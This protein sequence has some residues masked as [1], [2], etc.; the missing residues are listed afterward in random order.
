VG[1]YHSPAAPPN[2]FQGGINFRLLNQMWR[3]IYD[4]I[5]KYLG[6]T[7][8]LSSQLEDQVPM[9]DYH[10]YNLSDIDYFVNSREKSRVLI[11]NGPAMSGQSFADDM[12]DMIDL[13]AQKYP[14]ID[15]ICTKKFTTS[16][17]NIFFTDNIIKTATSESSS[18]VYWNPSQTRCDL[19]EISYLST[20]CDLIVG[21][22]SG[23]FVYCLT[24]QNLQDNTKTFVSFNNVE[25]DNLTYDLNINCSYI[26]SNNYDKN[27]IMQLLDS[28]LCRL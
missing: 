15:F 13:F 27:H 26:H 9:I 22:N 4:Q 10:F 14:K 1:A 7:L 25:I 2:F 11:S 3:Y 19:L 28:Q 12:H 8:T 20:H 21:K 16:Y 6:V 17:D 23:P 24:K 5:E 18:G